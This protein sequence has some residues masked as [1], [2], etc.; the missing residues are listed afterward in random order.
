MKNQALM[1][2]FNRWFNDD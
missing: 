2:G 1:A